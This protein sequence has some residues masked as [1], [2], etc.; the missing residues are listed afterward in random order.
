MKRPAIVVKSCGVRRD[1]G[2]NLADT[3]RHASPATYPQRLAEDNADELQ[4]LSQGE[5]HAAGSV[6][7]TSPHA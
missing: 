6:T 2:S 3:M 5:Q 1:H 7:Y 4:K